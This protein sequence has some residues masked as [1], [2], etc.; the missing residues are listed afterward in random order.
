MLPKICLI[1]ECGNP[2]DSLGYC[3]MHAQRLR[4]HGDL[5]RGEVP[6]PEQFAAKY[7]VDDSECWIW[8]GKIASNGYAVFGGVGLGAHRYS[9][10]LHNG[11]IPDGLQLDHLCMVKRC[12][13]PAHL[14]AVTPKENIRRKDVA[15]GTGS[16]KTHCPHGHPYDE[17]NT[18]RR[19]GR[20]Y[21][22]ACARNRA[23]KTYARK[24]AES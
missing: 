11:E 19:N 21:C 22:K 18:S 3:K 8:Q 9:Y 7:L 1:P 6:V 2:H 23:A 24:L 14:E 10:Q 5:D 13:N 17:A 15:Y 12:V 4:T 20:R 16:A